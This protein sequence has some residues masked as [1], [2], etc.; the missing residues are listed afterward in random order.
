MGAL[1]KNTEKEVKEKFKSFLISIH[2]LGFS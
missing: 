2:Y 1:L